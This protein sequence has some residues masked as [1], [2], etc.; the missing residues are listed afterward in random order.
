M[1]ND[2][3]D[4]I[5][6]EFSGEIKVA[7][8]IIDYLSSGLYDSPAACLKELINNAYDADA[9]NV[10]VFIKPD[11]DRI[12]I[13]DNGEG[14]DRSEF[15]KHFKMISESHKRDNSDVTKLGRLKIGKIGIGFIAAN[16]ICDVMEIVSTKSGSSELL[17]VTIR[18]D[19]MRKDPADRR[20][21]GD[22]IAEADYSGRVSSTQNN[23]HFTRVFLK[24]IRGEARR[25]FSGARAGRLSSGD[26]SLYGLKPESVLRQL[27]DEHLRSW[28]DFDEY[29]RNVLRVGLNV[30]VRYHEGWLPNSLDPI[31]GRVTRHAASRNFN[32]FFDGSEVRKPIIFSPPDRALVRP[33]NFEGKSV[34]AHGYFYAQQTGIHPQELQGLLIR[35]RDAAIGEYDQSFM[36]F[37]PNLGSLLQSWISAEISADD[38]LEEAMIIDRKTLRVSHPAYDEL[39]QAVHNFLE[40]FIKEVRNEIYLRGSDSRRIKRIQNIKRG[41][42]LVASEDTSEFSKPTAIFLDKAWRDASHNPIIQKKLLRRFTIDEFYQIVVEAAKEVLTPAQLERFV[43]ALTSRLRGE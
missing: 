26:K 27:K 23:S 8:R 33:F 34:S 35:I 9:T 40:L 36:G 37:S 12:I 16:E 3:K 38:R 1:T 11:A 5:N 39:Q 29:S 25:I 31:I 41:I 4:P 10:Y 2:M 30:P 7:S 14:L 21:E 24:E 6:P 20:R 13:E 17:E 19:L 22:S 28:A 42:S 32:L 18:F 43:K 15:E